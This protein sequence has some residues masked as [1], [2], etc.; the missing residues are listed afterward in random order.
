MA[1]FI[2]IRTVYEV[3]TI[4]KS[5][6]FEIG[7]YLKDDPKRAIEETSQHIENLIEDMICEGTDPSIV[8]RLFQ[9]YFSSNRQ[10]QI[11]CQRSKSRWNFARLDFEVRARFPFSVKY[12]AS[13]SRRECWRNSCVGRIFRFFHHEP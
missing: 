12:L 6:H 9:K 1:K 7:D 2:K 5:Q 3:D 13:D 4:R 8:R 10:A 11:R